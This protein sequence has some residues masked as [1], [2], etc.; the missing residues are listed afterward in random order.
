MET[1]WYY[2]ENNQRRGPVTEEE[3]KQLAASGQLKPTDKVWKKGMGSWGPASAVAGLFPP[4]INEEPPPLPVDG[5]PPPLAESDRPI[6][7]EVTT[8]P[9]VADFLPRDRATEE[10]RPM[11]R[12]QELTQAGAD[13]SCEAPVLAKR[14]E[15]PSGSG[16]GL[17]CPKCGAEN[18]QR[19]KV[20]YEA[21]RST[22][23]S[24]TVG[25][26]AAGRTIGAGVAGTSGEQQVLAQ[27]VRRNC[28][29]CQQSS[30][31]G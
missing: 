17:T 20:L 23:S 13:L 14:V 11:A 5:L 19:L 27:G 18:V 3:L 24:T 7:L 9:R 30:R 2:S 10:P 4:S 12:S 28:H 1:Q 29:P 8:P 16:R 6:T 25:V 21:T 26:A 31:S 22:A 15:N